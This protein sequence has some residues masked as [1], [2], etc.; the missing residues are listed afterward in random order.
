MTGTAVYAPAI[1]GAEVIVAE[2][3][4]DRAIVAT[5][6]FG[7]GRAVLLGFDYNQY[8][9]DMARIIANAVQLYGGLRPCP[10]RFDVRFGTDNPPPSIVCTG[11]SIA[12][13]PTGFLAPSTTYYWRVTA[14]NHL[15]TTD[16]P[17]WSFTTA[18]FAFTDFD[19]RIVITR[20]QSA[21]DRSVVLPQGVSSLREGQSAFVEFWAQDTGSINTGILCAF[22]DLS[23]D[24]GCFDVQT[25]VDHRLHHLVADVHQLVRGR[26]REVA[27]LVTQLVAEVRVLDPAAVPLAFDAVDRHGVGIVLVDR[28]P[29]GSDAV[30]AGDHAAGL[31]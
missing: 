6:Q 17:V 14:R 5:A 26:H 19:Y 13:C 1:P 25:A 18:P 7:P 27:F 24:R 30:R 12:S 23:F 9:S 28:E 11:S 3:I 29:S 15:G 16:G 8:N 4:T 21:L 20:D 22:A 2:A 31:A 10:I